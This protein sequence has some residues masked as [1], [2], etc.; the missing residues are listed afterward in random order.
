M[1]RYPAAEELTVEEITVDDIPAAEVA[2]EEA[3]AAVEEPAAAVELEPLV[4]QYPVVAEQPVAVEGAVEPE[5]E[6]V[7]SEPASHPG[8]LTEFV[9]ELESSLGD[10]FLPGTVATPAPPSQPQSVKRELPSV[11]AEPAVA[12][13]PSAPV[14][15][16]FVA[17]IEASLGE[18]FLK[19]AP[20][21]EPAPVTP[22]AKAM[23]A[24]AA[25][26]KTA[27]PKITQPLAVSAAA[28]S[29]SVTAQAAPAVPQSAPAAWPT[30]AAE[31]PRPQSPAKPAPPA[32]APPAA[33]KGSPFADDAGVDLAAMFGELKQ[34]LEA[35]VAAS[36]EDP[37]THYNLGI[38]F[39]EMGLLD[40]AIGELQKA[41]QSFDRGHPFPQIMQTYTWLAQCF[42]EKGVPEAAVRWYDKALN[43]TGIDGET[44]VALNYELAS[45]YESAGDKPAALKHFMDVYGNNIDYRDVAERIKALK[46]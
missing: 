14:L 11:H 44:R 42:L 26:V 33:A 7:A 28:A 22:V 40:E 36:D 43:V 12:A 17:D 21:P 20:V 46:S 10:S 37:E 32:P 6:P 3:P 1:S 38:A 19:A 8:V 4:A 39:R 27:P 23:R 41:C 13:E 9:S 35:D 30:P 24:P 25:P 31:T 2:V 34:D 18:D 5:P 29:G 45:A 15:G 16:E